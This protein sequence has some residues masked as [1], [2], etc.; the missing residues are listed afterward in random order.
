MTQISPHVKTMH[1]QQKGLFASLQ[2][3]PST[4]IQYYAQYSKEKNLL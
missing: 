3:F 1:L 2:Q 4:L